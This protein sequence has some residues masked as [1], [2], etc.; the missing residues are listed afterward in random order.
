M[1]SIFYLSLFILAS[2][3]CTVQADAQGIQINKIYLKN[4][5]NISCLDAWICGGDSVCYMKGNKGLRISLAEV[6]KD[7]TFGT[8]VSLPAD[9]TTSLP[10][11][12]PVAQ[13]PPETMDKKKAAW[14]EAI[15]NGTIMGNMA[16]YAKGIDINEPIDDNGNTPLHIASAQG[17]IVLAQFLV[18]NNADFKAKNI[19]GETP[20]DMARKEKHS[21]LV[22]YLRD[23]HYEAQRAIAGTAT[24]PHDR[25]RAEFD[26]AMDYEMLRHETESMDRF[27]SN[28]FH[29]FFSP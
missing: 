21:C 20:L 27:N 25:K 4:G 24:E 7:K 16:E 29:T 14:R 19:Q 2:I 5:T 12:T 26:R 13:Q 10:Q 28:P 8:E 23:P 15:F 9:Y 3:F 17:N 22:D 11:S 18:C 1:K 6:D